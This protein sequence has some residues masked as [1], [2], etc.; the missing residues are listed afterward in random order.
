ME[1]NKKVEELKA[2]EHDMTDALNG[3]V[4]AKEVLEGIET[5]VVDTYKSIEDGVVGTYQK[6]ENSVVGAY[7]KL[8]NK[9]VEKLF[10]KDGETVEEAKQRLKDGK[11]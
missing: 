4:T 9:M 7:E 8:E 1:N 5:A 10:T 3:N 6:L 11:L 2:R